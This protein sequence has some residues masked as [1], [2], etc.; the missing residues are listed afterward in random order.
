MILYNDKYRIETTR[1]DWCAYRTGCYFVT[2]C[3]CNREC[4]F[5]TVDCRG[6]VCYSQTGM[7]AHDE[8]AQICC[9]F[10]NV[11]MHA[12]VVM[13]NHVHILL[14]LDDDSRPLCD[15]VG[16]YKAGVSRK[17][18]RFGFI[19]AW[20]TRFHDHIVRTARAFDMIKRY[21]EHNPETWA[22]DCFHR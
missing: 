13:P 11:R 8:L 3:T 20:Q 9:R 21:I 16:G 22:E 14:S 6:K 18:H 7:V 10:P 4:V 2:I 17:C 15:V 1:A 19:F 5:G 12:S